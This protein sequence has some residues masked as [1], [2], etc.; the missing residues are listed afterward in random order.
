MLWRRLVFVA[1]AHI[2]LFSAL[3][4]AATV[5]VYNDEVYLDSDTMDVIRTV[6]SK[7]V[8][9][10]LEVFLPYIVRDMNNTMEGV[11]FMYDKDGF[12]D[13]IEETNHVMLFP[14]LYSGNVSILLP[15]IAHPH[16]KAILAYP[17]TKE[18]D[19]R[20]SM[21]GATQMQTPVFFLTY[22]QGQAIVDRIHKFDRDPVADLG[23][24]AP[25]N[26]TQ[27][28]RTPQNTRQRRQITDSG[29]TGNNT[30]MDTDEILKSAYQR[31][32][33]RLYYHNDSVLAV[34]TNGV[35]LG[36]VL[37]ITIPGVLGL[38]AVTTFLICYR[39]HRRRKHMEIEMFN[40]NQRNRGRL[41]QDM[42]SKPDKSRRAPP[43]HTNQVR[44]L[45][46]VVV[47]K[48]NHALFPQATRAAIMQ[49]LISGE[50]FI[51]SS[52]EEGSD[53][54]QLD[55]TM[56]PNTRL[57]RK[58]VEGLTSTGDYNSSSSPND[59]PLTPTNDSL[60]PD[61]Y[62]DNFEKYQLGTSE[63]VSH[64]Q[65]Q[66]ENTRSD[67]VAAATL[68][69]MSMMMS[70]K[71]SQEQLRSTKEK[72][73][74]TVGNRQPPKRKSLVNLLN[75]TTVSSINSMGPTSTGGS[76]NFPHSP[77]TP[78]GLQHLARDFS[79]THSSSSQSTP[80]CGVCQDEFDDGETAR[81]LP[82]RHLF[83]PTCVDPWLTRKMARCPL[84]KRN[85]VG[86]RSRPRNDY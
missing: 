38:I 13:L 34:K 82:C 63:L 2:T 59:D 9:K 83:H 68:P 14:A 61:P 64:P 50:S 76:H 22:V 30:T 5:S 55:S 7:E 45:S 4:L 8:G 3:A 33:A 78:L 29:N 12:P 70:K 36:L 73:E 74:A 48:G 16:L 67:D 75:P 35:N 25:T 47:T 17:T 49:Y 44:R 51:T 39:H 28:R 84:C 71:S 26:I 86:A 11:V 54:E 85:C 60:Y 15:N 81:R 10:D 69:I 18:Y 24:D 27:E 6:S 57:S 72:E 65:N 58:T 37:G 62:G 43:M 46:T 41:V 77:N 31:N 19:G 21:S 80:V 20:L 1:L 32:I 66:D 53:V 56:R 79:A 42:L 40:E 52:D 23:S